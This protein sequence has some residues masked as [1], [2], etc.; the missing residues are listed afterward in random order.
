MN[1]T[2][3]STF[4]RQRCKTAPKLH[5]T[6]NTKSLKLFST[7][8]IQILSLVQPLQATFQCGTF[9]LKKIQSEVLIAGTAQSRY[10]KAVLLNTATLIQYTVFRWLAHK[11]RTILSVSATMEDSVSGNRRCSKTTPGTT[12]R[13]KFPRQCVNNWQSPQLDLSLKVVV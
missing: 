1:L 11:M 7:L 5:S 9:E 12:L 8:M 3:S 10:K 2:A 6:A 4:T 13:L